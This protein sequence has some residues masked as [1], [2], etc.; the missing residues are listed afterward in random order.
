VLLAVVLTILTYS[1]FSADLKEI[2]LDYM[3]RGYCYATSPT[4]AEAWHVPIGN[5][6]V[7]KPNAQLTNGVEGELSLVVLPQEE[8]AFNKDYHGFRLLL[9]NRT[10][11]TINIPSCDN[12]LAIVQ[13]GLEGEGLWRPIEYLPSSW[14]GNSYYSVTLPSGHYWEFAAPRYKGTIKTTLRFVL[15]IEGQNPIFSNEFEGSVNPGQFT[16]KQGHNPTNLMDPYD[17]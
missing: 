4:N 14:C 16:R 2:N 17:E 11:N 12:R 13:Q 15:T 3:L 6:N 7:P 5:G 9:V 10:G 8:V 1:A